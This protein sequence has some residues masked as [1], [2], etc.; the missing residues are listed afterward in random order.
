MAKIKFVVHGRHWV[1]LAVVNRVAHVIG[2][3][4]YCPPF[5]QESG[6]HWVLNA[7]NDWWLEKSQEP[8]EPCTYKFAGRYADQTLMDSFKV[9]LEYIFR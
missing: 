4:E 9:V 3:D 1:E 6:Y 5:T 2:F 8:Q 7:T